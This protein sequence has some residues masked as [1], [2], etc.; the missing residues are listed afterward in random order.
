V[1]VWLCAGEG[2]GPAALVRELM[3]GAEAGAASEALGGS[4]SRLRLTPR[5]VLSLRPSDV[6]LRRI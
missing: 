2:T 3:W 5:V 6:A 4:P 1:V